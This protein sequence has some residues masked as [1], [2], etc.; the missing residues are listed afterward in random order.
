ME[1][2]ERIN[3][4]RAKAFDVNIVQYILALEIRI[5]DLEKIVKE[6]KTGLG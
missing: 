6:L 1:T 4:L 3:A 2:Q 5:E